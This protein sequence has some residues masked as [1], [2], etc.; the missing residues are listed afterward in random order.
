MDYW[1]AALKTVQTDPL[2]GTGPGTFQ[3]PYARLKAPEAEMARLTHNDY[4][5]QFSDSG[6]P[7]GLFYLVWIGAW[8]FGAARP[9]WASPDPLVM[10]AG[11]GVSAWL[12]QG[13]SEFSL[14]VPALAWTAFTLAGSVAA[15]TRPET[16]RTATLPRFAP[17]AA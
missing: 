8:V 10:A 1:S 7:G 13:L 14:Y 9:S 5:Q 15:L 11:L 12:L 3:R 4:L 16:I 2:L 6:V 17:R